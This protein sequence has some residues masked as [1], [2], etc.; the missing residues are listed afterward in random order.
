MVSSEDEQTFGEWLRRRRRS[1]DLTEEQ[2]GDL[3]GLA[4]D[5]VRAYESGRRRPSREAVAAM[6]KYLMISDEELPDITRLA[7]IGTGYHNG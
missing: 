1:L 3:T 2:L 5:T 6:A 4:P 7:R